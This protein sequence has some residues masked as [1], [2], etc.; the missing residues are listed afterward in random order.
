M[1]PFSAEIWLNIFVIAIL[2][3]MVMRSV[4]QEAHL[5]QD[6]CLQFYLQSY[7]KAAFADN[8]AQKL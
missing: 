8:E 5:P 6:A 3:S 7:I 1:L 4:S 2:F